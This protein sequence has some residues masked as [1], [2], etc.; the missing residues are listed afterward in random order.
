MASVT[1]NIRDQDLNRLIPA[2]YSGVQSHRDGGGVVQWQF[3]DGLKVNVLPDAR[4]FVAW[5]H[6]EGGRRVNSRGPSH[7]RGAVDLVIAVEGVDF[8]AALRRLGGTERV[9]APPAPRSAEPATP[10]KLPPLDFN[11][12]SNWPTVR[13]YLAGERQ[14]PEALVRKI[15]NQGQVYAGWGDRAGGFLIFPCRPWDRPTS[16]SHGPA[17][18]GAILRWA[19]PGKPPVEKYY[20]QTAPTAKGSK[21]GAGWWQIGTG[22]DAV[23]AVEAPIDGLTLMA[24]AGALGWEHRVTIVASGGMGG[25]TAR[26]WQGAPVVLV[27]TDRD[28]AGD[29][30]ER[31]IRGQVH[32]G[33]TVGRLRPPDGAKDWNDAWRTE[34]GPH[35]VVAVLRHGLE[36][37]LMR[38][39]S[40]EAE[41]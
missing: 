9:P 33:Q 26:Q 40:M 1:N 4:G 8:R 6:R 27:A 25:F 13:D 17:P 2:L 22:R 15:F 11:P 32:P 18:T 14:I 41:R 3:A 19:Q 12:E 7:G 21:K 39:R 29:G 30:F 37:V 36:P 28:V 35:R 34:G 10:F 23:L 16:R 20:G 24:A 5:D 38:Q 31:I